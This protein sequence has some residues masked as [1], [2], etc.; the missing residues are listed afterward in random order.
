MQW[1]GRA[2]RPLW[3]E[4]WHAEWFGDE[5]GQSWSFLGSLSLPISIHSTP[6]PLPYKRGLREIPNLTSTQL[7]HKSG[8]Y[9][10][11]LFFFFFCKILH[12]IYCFFFLFQ[13]F[14]QQMLKKR[15][16]CAAHKCWPKYT[17]AEPRK[18]LH[19]LT[20]VCLSSLLFTSRSLYMLKKA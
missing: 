20:E 7:F 18:E 9:C 11:Q 1:A 4:I 16:E 5:S 13:L 15:L 17:I 6:P 2:Q 8:T 3:Y 14:A 19:Q 12:Q 10:C